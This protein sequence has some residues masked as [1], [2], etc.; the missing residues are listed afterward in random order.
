ML[1][2]GDLFPY[3][4]R[5]PPLPL[6]FGDAWVFTGAA[7]VRPF[8]EIGVAQKAYSP[9]PFIRR[10]SPGGGEAQKC[11]FILV[12]Q[13]FSMM[14]V[15]CEEDSQCSFFCRLSTLLYSTPRIGVFL[16]GLG[17]VFPLFLS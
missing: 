3:H 13:A 1:F 2:G 9:A 7:L 5:W 15:L 4:G 16:F 8:P 11:S 14:I 10:L 12:I 6:F 17:Q